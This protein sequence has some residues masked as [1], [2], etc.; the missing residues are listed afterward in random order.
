[1]DLLATLLDACRERPEDDLPRRV[2]GDWLMDGPDAAAQARGEFIHLQL[3]LAAGKK[4]GQGR[5]DELL[6]AHREAWLGPLAGL[7]AT[8]ARGLVDVRVN[9]AEGHPR[10][11][12]LLEGRPPP[13]WSWVSGLVLR[14]LGADPLR[15]LPGWEG[16]AGVAELQVHNP[17]GEG[18]LAALVRSP[19]FRP[20]SFHLHGDRMGRADLSALGAMAVSAVCLR[21]CGL[22]D[23]DILSLRDAPLF[24]GLRRLGLPDNQLH[25]EAAEALAGCPALGGLKALN[26]G[27]NVISA[28]G[29]KKLGNAAHLGGLEEL[30]L[31][32]NGIRDEGAME[33]Y[34]S[35]LGHRLRR[36]NLV[37][38]G[39][40]SPSVHRLWR[41][42][43]GDGVEF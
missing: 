43:L 18:W 41:G 17:L 25:A 23:A 13:E 35:P 15:A 3:D 16:L 39:V 7:H 37:S 19:H 9:G 14:S 6:A 22:H 26:L 36:L 12:R 40:L 24:T 38:N 27:R 34:R 4:G 29:A 42:R 28:A 32:L 21:S 2:L 30:D 8:F 33:L 10:L 20:A 1:M 31:R 11:V 5:H